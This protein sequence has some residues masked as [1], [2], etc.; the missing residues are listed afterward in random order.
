MTPTIPRVG[1]AQVTAQD[2]LSAHGAYS[3]IELLLETNL[4]GYDEYRAWR[5]GECHTLDDAIA[6]AGHEIRALVERLDSWARSL[7]LHA[8]QIALYGI[9]GHA[10][11]DLVA[12]N[13][14]ALDRLLHTEYRAANDR[15][16]RDIFLDTS[17]TQAVDDLVASLSTRDTSSATNH[18]RRLQGMDAKHWALGEARVLIDALNAEPPS[19]RQDG[20]PQLDLL[21]HRWL[22]A[23]WALLRTDARDFITPSW[24]AIGN[25]LEDG[26]A[27]DATQPRQHASWA[28]LN[29]L[30]W[31]GVRRTVHSEADYRAHPVLVCRLAEA[32]WR[33]R[34]RKAALGLWFTLCWQAP[35]HFEEAVTTLRFPDSAIKRTWQRLRDNDAEP[36]TAA[37]FPARMVLEDTSVARAAKLCGGGSDPER[38][39]DLLLKLKVGGSDREDMENGRALQGLAPELFERYLASLDA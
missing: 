36:L 4:L 8:E 32:E 14:A 2:L 11:T 17:E 27:F 16:Q 19:G 18:V 28:Y 38:A 23:A 15:R 10:G 12:S 6:D 9:D 21:E 1:D 13:D 26:T 31:A 35:E 34:N 25:A 29:G 24:R 3:P 39:F 33:L 22:P 7:H 30:D 37:W 20:L 5:R